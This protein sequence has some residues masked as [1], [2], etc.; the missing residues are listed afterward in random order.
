MNILSF[1]IEEWF[2]EQQYFG[3]HSERYEVFNGY[4]YKLLS[5]LDEKELK[6]TFFC[7]GGIARKFP[8]VVK[9]IQKRG[10]DIGCHSDMH[11]WMNKMS[12]TEA[13]ED[14]HRAVDSIEQLIGQKVL[15]YRAPAFTIGESNKWMFDI[16]AENG[17]EIDASIYP[18][19]RD[20]G[21]C[22]AF[23]KHCPTIVRHNGIA[24]KEF[25][26]STTRVLGKEM[27]YSGGGFFRL[28]PFRF[29][30]KTMGKK[31]YN[32]AYF[33]IGDLIPEKK[34]SLMS[35]LN[36]ILKYLPQKRID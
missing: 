17:I 7:I 26:V 25:P 3:N 29:V 19:V 6:A 9:E 14:T 18:A 12:E 24:L 22:A 13:R 10:H 5:K 23:G 16:L 35:C 36:N 33:H 21:G 34:T 31:D 20:F 4:L 2:L 15:S 32:M 30:L 8:N 11:A 27:A 28:F 1:D